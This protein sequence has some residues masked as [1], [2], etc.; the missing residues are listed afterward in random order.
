VPARAIDADE[1]ER[2]GIVTRVVPD[3]EILDAAIALA[4]ELCEFTPFGLFATKQVMWA[5]VDIPNLE[6]AIQLENR[7]QIMASASGE[8]EEAAR[9]F[10]EKRKPHWSDEG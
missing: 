8:T 2:Y 7:N 9:A 3:E 6:A 5:N 4:D 10:F 1:A